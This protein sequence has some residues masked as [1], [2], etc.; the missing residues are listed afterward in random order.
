MDEVELKFLNINPEEIQKKLEALGAVKKFD[1]DTQSYAFHDDGFSP[2]DST[3]K[4][5][6]VRKI[7]GKSYMTF[8]APSKGVDATNREETEIEVSDFEAAVSVLEHIGFEKGDLFEKRRTHYELPD[9]HFELD[10]VADIPTYLEI[11][12]HSEEDMRVMCGKLGLDMA[13]GKKG[14]IFEIL[15][16]KF[17][18]TNY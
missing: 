13:D 6:R 12:T 2:S 11:E 1:A 15:P 4:S 10:T 17:K 14:T 5:L 18:G 16:E 7:G 3:Q 8:K 9:A